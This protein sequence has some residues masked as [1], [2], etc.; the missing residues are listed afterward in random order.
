MAQE[1]AIEP[2]TLHLPET[3]LEALRSRLGNAAFP[4]EL[5]GAEWDLG[6]PLADVKRLATY[7]RDTFDWRKVEERINRLPQFRTAIQATGFEPLDIHFVH[8]QSKVAGAIPLLFVH[9]CK[10]AGVLTSQELCPL[11]KFLSLPLEEDY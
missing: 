4:D 8:A 2:F 1:A 7:W 3:Q 6:A 11:G 10:S 5:H 9:G